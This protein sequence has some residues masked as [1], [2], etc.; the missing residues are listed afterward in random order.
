MEFTVKFEGI[1][2]YAARVDPETVG[3]DRLDK[4]RD[5]ANT[6]GLST[7]LV[8]GRIL[9]YVKDPEIILREETARE[10]NLFRAEDSVK[11]L[12][13]GGFLDKYI[14]DVVVIYRDNRTGA[15]T[16]GA[17]IHKDVNVTKILAAWKDAGY[18]KNWEIPEDNE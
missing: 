12:V 5:A 9:S 10:T 14:E 7:D 15:V 16:N 18:P 13:P 1:D 8:D 17:H 11:V 2:G 6:P 3:I 4:I